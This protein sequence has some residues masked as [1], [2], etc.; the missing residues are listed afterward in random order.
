MQVLSNITP[1]SLELPAS[2]CDSS[3]T[4]SDPLQAAAMWVPSQSLPSHNMSSIPP[5][6]DGVLPA[7]P[8][9]TQ[10]SVHFPLAE[11]GLVSSSE[12][13][14]TREMHNLRLASLQLTAV[15]AVSVLATCDKFTELLLGKSFFSVSILPPLCGKSPILCL[16]GERI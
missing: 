9:L 3:I 7:S 10:S 1:S 12:L 16:K 13:H 15:K 6:S 14:H 4:H 5:A 2:P 11:K 8:K